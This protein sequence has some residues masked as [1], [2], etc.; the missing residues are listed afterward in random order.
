MCRLHSGT[1][2]QYRRCWACCSWG[3]TT[4][5]LAQQP[6]RCWC[7]CMTTTEPPP[8]YD[9]RLVLHAASCLCIPGW[10]FLR[11]GP[12]EGCGE[13][14]AS[15]S[16]MP[17]HNACLCGFFVWLARCHC[18]ATSKTTWSHQDFLQRRRCSICVDWEGACR[19]SRRPR[20]ESAG[21]N[22]TSPKACLAWGSSA[23]HCQR[24]RVSSI[25]IKGLAEYTSVGLMALSHTYTIALSRETLDTA[26][27]GQEH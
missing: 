1:P 27:I 4:R 18:S 16:V 20:G 5:Q 3:L 13:R 26:Q 12:L 9:A 8:G 24:R 10:H 21:M 23:C 15:C 2:A 7:C 25:D 6:K 14:A 17:S 19:Y 22:V 11:M